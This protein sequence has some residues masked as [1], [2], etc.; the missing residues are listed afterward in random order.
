M[1]NNKLFRV[2]LYSTDSKFLELSGL[3]Y[4]LEVGN[5]TPLI[6]TSILPI[7]LLEPFN[8]SIQTRDSDILSFLDFTVV[9]GIRTRTE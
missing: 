7:V 5:L 1:H 8:Y 9:S 4:R 3:A 2:E 6:I